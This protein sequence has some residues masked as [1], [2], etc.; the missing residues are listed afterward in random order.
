MA[1]GRAN[2]GRKAGSVNKATAEM[3]KTKEAFISRVNKNAHKL[4]NSQLDLAIGEKYLMVVRTIGK[5]SKQ[6]RETSIVTDPE[7]IMQYLDETLENTDEEYYFMTTK[8]ADNKALD[9]LLNRSF[10]KPTESI[11]L[12]SLGEKLPTV[13]IEGTYGREPGFRVNNNTAEVDELA[14]D[15]SQQSS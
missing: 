2:N 14:E 3:R 10:G 15:S 11:D 1:D 5:G 4:F 12:T 8:A 7:L 6:R 13:I 9:S